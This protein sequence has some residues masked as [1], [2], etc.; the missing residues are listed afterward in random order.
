MEPADGPNVVVEQQEEVNIGDDQSENFGHEA[1]DDDDNP[2]DGH[3]DN[4]GDADEN[5]RQEYGILDSVID[6]CKHMR[7]MVELFPLHLLSFSFSYNEGTYVLIQDVPELDTTQLD[8]PENVNSFM[9]ATYYLH[10]TYSP[11]MASIRR[12]IIVLAECDGMD[13]TKKP[14][15]KLIHNV[16]SQLLSC[17]P[18]TGECRLFHTG[19]AFNVLAAMLR[20]FLPKDLR[21][22]FQTGFVFEGRLDTFYLTPDVQT[23]NRR[24]LARLEEALTRRFEN[25]RVF[26]L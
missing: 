18:F 9:A 12:G 5:F 21:R 2:N 8:T 13:W 14:D 23:A 25:E 3:G 17:Y 24:L 22:Q 6:G 7:R 15:F 4:N 20:R 16:F 19:V 1:E 11:D 10:T 26:R